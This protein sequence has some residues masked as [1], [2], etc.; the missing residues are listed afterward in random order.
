MQV[1][2]ATGFHH[3]L[4]SVEDEMFKAGRNFL[5]VITVFALTWSALSQT[6]PATQPDLQTQVDQA[7]LQVKLAQA[8]KDI[9]AANQGKAEADAAAFKAKLGSIDTT[10]LPTGKVTTD[11]KVVIEAN[12]LAYAAATAAASRIADFLENSV[13][14]QNLAFYT[15]KDQDG[16][17]AYRLLKE[18]IT[19][20]NKNL[21]GV[22]QVL[23]LAPVPNSVL[24]E[25]DGALQTLY[26]FQSPQPPPPPAEGGKVQDFIFPVTPAAV[27]SSI[28]AAM[29]L[30]ALFKVDTS[31]TGVTI[32]GDDL[33]LQALVASAVREHCRTRN[34]AFQVYQP[35]YS[36]STAKSDLL[37]QLQKL[38]GSA[39][40]FT[41]RATELEQYVKAPLDTAIASTTK[42]RDRILAL[43]AELKTI[44]VQLKANPSR[45][46]K[47]KLQDQQQADTV[48]LASITDSVRTD[49]RA[50]GLVNATTGDIHQVAAALIA[51]YEAD[52]Y[53]V[54]QRM[55]V[56]KAVAGRISD[57]V[58]AVSKPDSTGASPLQGILRSEALENG[59][60][61][62]FLLMTKI[63]SV[64]GN[65]INKRNAFWSSLSFSGG[66]VAEFLLNN[67]VGAIAQS[68]TVECY[69]GRIKEGNLQK[70]LSSASSIVC[71][72]EVDAANPTSSTQTVA[73]K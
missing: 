54:Q 48:E 50:S 10:N 21:G 60:G 7:Q 11:D 32:T 44:A 59:L 39:D 45:T 36:Y 47:T 24:P 23:R 25:P 65:N 46:Q 57:L 1:R 72:P 16:I 3:T 70:G 17:Q 62:S 53:A 34:P 29:G 42:Q 18:Q 9:A 13:C 4:S 37:A 49:A 73:G 28:N 8:Q 66:I 69:G 38:P 41:V 30:I 67:N 58:S 55:A 33:A 19:T 2:A 15:G 12:Y 56:L 68:G 14:S 71:S 20:L 22:N 31:Y 6:Q 26:T 27:T 5:T 64:G 63:V 35:T 61:Q 43:E 52:Q 40:D 51:R